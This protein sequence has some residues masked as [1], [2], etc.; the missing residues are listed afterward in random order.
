MSDS[1]NKS[2]ISTNNNS[3]NNTSND[4]S[5]D[6]INNSEN[7]ELKKEIDNNKINEINNQMFHISNY[8]SGIDK[9]CEDNTTEMNHMK[10]AFEEVNTTIIEFSKKLENLT[11]F[12]KLI[13][14]LLNKINKMKN[15][16][17]YWQADFLKNMND[18]NEKIM[19]QEILLDQLEKFEKVMNTKIEYL[20]NEVQKQPK[21]IDSKID[22][23]NI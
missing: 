14:E 7:Y 9:K 21:L 6:I 16:N 11:K 13:H 1:N 23:V 5:S 20:I 4:C 15:H 12:E 18:F 8:I 19:N 2:F 3:S 22:E 17:S 10:S